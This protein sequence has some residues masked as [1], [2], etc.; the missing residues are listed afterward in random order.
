MDFEE[1]KKSHKWTAE[2]YNTYSAIQYAA[3][4]ELLERFSFTGE[5]SVLDIGCGDGKITAKLSSLA[6]KGQ[7]AGMDISPEMV[8]F[9]NKYFPSKKWANLTF[10]EADANE[11]SYSEEFDVI[12]SSFALQWLNDHENFLGRAFDALKKDGFWLFT[13]PLGISQELEDSLEELIS[14]KKWCSYFSESNFQLT[15]MPTE[16]EWRKGLS[17]VPIEL[18]QCEKVDQSTNFP[19]YSS[20]KEYIK[21]WLPHPYALP[22]DL[23]PQFYEEL[24]S[25]HSRWMNLTKESEV[26]F[27]FPRLDIIGRKSRLVPKVS[28]EE[29]K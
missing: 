24:F 21:Q 6:S 11:L 19:S 28:N 17:K 14:Q 12:F 16:G 18:T 3:A 9:A 5:E 10:I 20:L 15:A 29:V 23:R 26:C 8:A 25:L 27:T 13:I 4:I 7:V 22:S 2:D 1:I